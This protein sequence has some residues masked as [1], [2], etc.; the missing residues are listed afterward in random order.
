MCAH[1]TNSIYFI[2]VEECNRFVS[3]FSGALVF[4][5]PGRGCHG[6]PFGE[7]EAILLIS[8]SSG[9]GFLPSFF[10]DWPQTVK[11]KRGRGA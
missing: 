10:R 5:Y 11:D 7:K 4:S 3:G 6:G 2:A 8:L 9:R 1:F